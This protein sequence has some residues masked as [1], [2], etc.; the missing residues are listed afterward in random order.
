MQR[1]KITIQLPHKTTYI[2]II[3]SNEHLINHSSSLCNIQYFENQHVLRFSIM[4]NNN[5]GNAD[6][7]SFFYINTR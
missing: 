4:K 7:F 2:N 3:F 6:T 1:Q 5:F